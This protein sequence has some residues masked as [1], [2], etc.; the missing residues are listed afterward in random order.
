MIG[1]RSNVATEQCDVTN[2]IYDVAALSEKQISTLSLCQ[3]QQVL[4]W[5]HIQVQPMA[6]PSK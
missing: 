3:V 2:R 1:D 5:D 6:I 4:A